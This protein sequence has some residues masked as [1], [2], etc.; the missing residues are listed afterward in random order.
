MIDLALPQRMR[1]AVY[2]GPHDISLKEVETPRVGAAD[3]LIQVTTC[4]ICGS[5]VHS[6][7]TG[8]YVQRG[9]IMGHEFM[10][11]V[12]ETG[13]TDQVINRPEHPYTQALLSAVPIPDPRIRRQ[14]LQIKGGVSKPIDPDP[15]CRFFE[16]C[17]IADNY[18]EQSQHPPLEEV[19]G[20]VLAACYK[21]ERL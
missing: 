17:P 14:A 8:L 15:R 18:C 9:Q 10:G 21:T 12:V 7:K 20:S 1:A 2:N 3:I 19:G 11:R 4:G 16:R 6:Y 13:E 5:D